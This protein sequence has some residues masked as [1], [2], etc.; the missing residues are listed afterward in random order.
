MLVSHAAEKQ[1][2]VCKIGGGFTLPMRHNRFVVDSNGHWLMGGVQASHSLSLAHTLLLP[3]VSVAL[4]V[5]GHVDDGKLFSVVV[6]GRKSM[7]RGK[8]R[9]CT[10]NLKCA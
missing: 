3:A 10:W 7:K 1:C 2:K 4:W 8:S 9:M 5:I 6:R